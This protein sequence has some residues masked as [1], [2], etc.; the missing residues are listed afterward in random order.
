MSEALPAMY[1]TQA[2]LNSMQ[3]SFWLLAKAF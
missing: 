3:I 2:I 1:V